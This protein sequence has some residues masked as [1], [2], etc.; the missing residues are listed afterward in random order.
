MPSICK[1]S[2]SDKVIFVNY[3]YDILEQIKDEHK[4]RI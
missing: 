3:P 1:P 2:N 4:K